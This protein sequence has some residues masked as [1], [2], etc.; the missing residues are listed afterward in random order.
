MYVY[1]CVCVCMCVLL[2][3]CLESKAFVINHN[4]NMQSNIGAPG[5][6][7]IW[8]CSNTFYNTHMV[9]AEALSGRTCLGGKVCLLLIPSD[10]SAY[11]NELLTV[12]RAGSCI[13]HCYK[14]ML[15]LIQDV[16]G[17]P[18]SGF[19]LGQFVTSSADVTHA[20]N[21]RCAIEGPA[22]PLQ[23]TWILHDFTDPDTHAHTSLSLLCTCILCNCCHPPPSPA[24]C[25]L[26]Q[27]FWLA[28]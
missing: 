3:R 17:G 18:S 28:C 2:S 1:V 23:R 26:Y 21:C 25:L 8:F 7:G 9:K 11:W 16:T 27:R 24:Y 19:T 5:V 10:S 13:Q 4:E 14:T 15:T 12:H 20:I 6:F 22:L